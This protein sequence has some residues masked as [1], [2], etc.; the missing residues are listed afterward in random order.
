MGR[1]R[2]IYFEETELLFQARIQRQT[3]KQKFR[4]L[5][6]QVLQI[7]LIIYQ[8]SKKQNLEELQILKTLYKLT[9]DL[10]IQGFHELIILPPRNQSQ[11]SDLC[12]LVPKL[13]LFPQLINS[14]LTDYIIISSFSSICWINL[15]KL[16]FMLTILK[17][18]IPNNV[19]TC[20][21]H[22]IHI[23]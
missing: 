4:Y 11:L 13:L 1:N 23:F 7:H 20:P 8:A 3:S 10:K 21:F 5:F 19:S 18:T 17:I 2:H 9:E 16:S 22:S 15:L 14:L 6:F 12:S